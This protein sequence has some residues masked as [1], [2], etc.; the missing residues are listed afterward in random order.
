MDGCLREF[1]QKLIVALVVLL[2]VPAVAAAA[3]DPMLD[4]QWAL[5]NPAQ[6][7]A[8]VAW[9]Q[10]D[11]AGVVVAVLDTGVQLNHPDLDG[12]IWTNPHEIPGNG[13]DDDHNGVIDDI[14]G[15]NM[16]DNSPNVNDDNGHGTH[17][18]GIIAAR[19]DNG[20]GGTGLAPAATIM[21]VK[22]LDQN[23]TGTTD[24]LARGI[25]YAADAGAKILNV[26]VNSD[27]QT[28]DVTDAVRYAGEHG[29]VV[30]ASAGNNGRNIDLLPSYPAALADP[31]IISVAA[32]SE[33]NILWSGSNTGTTSVDLAAPGDH[34]LSTA[35]G[36]GYQSRTGTSAAAPFVSAALALLSAASPQQ[37]MSDLRNAIIA[38]T[39]RSNLLSTLL[40]SGGRL[41]VGAAM[42]N[43][44][45]PSSWR[46]GASTA[47]IVPKLR[48]TARRKARAGTRIA[49]RWRATGAAT[50]R[51]WRVSLDGRVIRRIRVKQG[52]VSRKPRK[53]YLVRYSAA[54]DA[55]PGVRSGRRGRPRHGPRTDA[56]AG[57]GPARPRRR[58][59]A[60][61]RPRTWHGTHAGPHRRA[62][63]GRQRDDR[64][65]ADAHGRSHVRRGYS[66]S[67]VTSGANAAT[68][69]QHTFTR[70]H[71]RPA[72]R[73]VLRRAGRRL[74][75]PADRRG[76][77]LL[78]RPPRR[79]RD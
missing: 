3:P 23:M 71:G 50:V 5:S 17:V 22:V 1:A 25:R 31:A 78:D 48:L 16:F 74:G 64:P 62:A 13:K 66:S 36:S 21:P 35:L 55:R 7:G 4:Q 46:S 8:D 77:G 32:S 68:I 69:R 59:H 2:A 12:A 37:P 51:T 43:I 9:T 56:A 61:L 38:T 29:A 76:D 33:S 18:A 15:A 10:S 58:R 57:L 6:V 34:V 41:D 30:V 65:H 53:Q 14:H 44:I 45:S 67:L 39:R 24:D 42:H 52:G 47:A 11:G 79:R 26:S 63:R 73:R 28:P 19:K 49:V 72:Q 70:Y 20:I 27:T 54:G 40:G 60:R 75:P